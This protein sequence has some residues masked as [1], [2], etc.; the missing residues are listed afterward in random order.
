MAGWGEEFGYV[1]RMVGCCLC[2]CWVWIGTKLGWNG[3]D[4]AWYIIVGGISEYFHTQGYENICCCCCCCVMG[5][6]A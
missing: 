5:L 3:L 2:C 1:V 4:W 6:D